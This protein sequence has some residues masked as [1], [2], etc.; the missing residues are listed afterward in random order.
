M[1]TFTISITETKIQEANEMFELA[2]TDGKDYIADYI[3]LDLVK[4][5]KEWKKIAL[6]SRV[7]DSID[8]NEKELES[9][10]KDGGLLTWDCGNGDSDDWQSDE[11]SK[12]ATT[13]NG[14][15]EARKAIIL[16]LQY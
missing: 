2:I 1:T 13:L 5:L 10:A 4:H 6:L 12:V 15:Y 14:L 11:Y 16:S 9:I 3:D 8:T 7:V